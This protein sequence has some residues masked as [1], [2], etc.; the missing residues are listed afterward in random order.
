MLRR[1]NGSAKCMRACETIE[2][3]NEVLKTIKWILE[4]I[5]KES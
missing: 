5:G 1:V 2:L 3:Y 4:N